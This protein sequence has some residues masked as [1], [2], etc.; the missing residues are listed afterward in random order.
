MDRT[1][2][3]SEDE[4]RHINE[5]QGRYFDQVVEIFERAL[6]EDV[7]ERLEKIV[8]APEIREGDTVLDVGAG[9]GALTPIILR[10]KPAKVIACDLSVKMLESLKG[11]FP[12]VET[13]I[14]DVRDL[15]LPDESVDVTFINALFGNIADKHSALA[16][17]KRIMKPSSRLII[18]HPEGRM[19]VEGL[20][21]RVP[22]PL[23]SLPDS[24]EGNRL[25][26]PHGFEIVRY[27]DEPKLYI[28]L[29]E[30]Q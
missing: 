24:V 29:A 1:K 20:K 10:Y 13:H 25:L 2:K 18:S 17:L 12:S 7:V 3:K 4:I 21:G 23:D 15:S 8:A 22:F 30:K 16:N 19:F 27:V 28:I 14:C 9:T 26:S 11:R 6:P 5:V